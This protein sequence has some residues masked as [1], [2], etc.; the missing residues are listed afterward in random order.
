MVTLGGTVASLALLVA[1][2]TVSGEAMLPVRVTIAA[3]M[4]PSRTEVAVMLT[5]TVI[6]R[7]ASSSSNLGRRVNRSRLLAAR[8]L[9]AERLTGRGR[10][11]RKGF[12]AV[13]SL[14]GGEKARRREVFA[15][16]P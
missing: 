15:H 4:L 5:V 16:G 1:R 13:W 12:T 2:L 10:L 9:R 11:E 14:S 8:P 6:A 7:R 3:A